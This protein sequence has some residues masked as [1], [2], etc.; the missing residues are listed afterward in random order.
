MTCVHRGSIS[1]CRK[2]AA[3]YPARKHRAA[4][5]VIDIISR[6]TTASEHPVVTSPVL[7]D[8]TRFS[9]AALHGAA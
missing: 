9:L 1:F 8:N 4:L 6:A 5:T 7:V 2:E 3:E